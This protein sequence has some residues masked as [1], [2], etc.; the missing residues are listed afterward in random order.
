MTRIH[1]PRFPIRQRVNVAGQPGYIASAPREENGWTY[2]VRFDNGN[3]AWIAEDEIDPLPSPP[4]DA[5]EAA[6]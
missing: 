5:S 4:R 2:A 6:A 3:L 1:T